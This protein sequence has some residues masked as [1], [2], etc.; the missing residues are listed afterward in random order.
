MKVVLDTNV[1]VSGIFFEASPAAQILN[2]WLE[3]K[4]QVFATPAILEEY[5][6][7]LERFSLLKAPVLEHDWASMLSK[8]CHVLP[9]ETSPRRISRDPADDKFIFCALHAGAE[10]L[11][12]GDKDLK[13]LE[14]D[15]PFQI[16]S[17]R[18]FRRIL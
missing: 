6:Q 10:Y 2:F 5:R 4:F 7:V 11:V 16:I 8:A 1:L 14:G 13:V 3:G 15:F 9:D 12:S 17:L 18:N